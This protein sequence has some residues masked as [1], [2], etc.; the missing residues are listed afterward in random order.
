MSE[1]VTFTFEFSVGTTY[2]NGGGDEVVFKGIGTDENHV[3]VFYPV[4]NHDLDMPVREFINYY[5]ELG[6]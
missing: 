5:W 4:G 3:K 2:V 1:K 6:E